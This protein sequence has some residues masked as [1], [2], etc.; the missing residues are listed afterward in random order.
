MVNQAESRFGL[1]S[2]A[3][4]TDR[5]S[6]IRVLDPSHVLRTPHVAITSSRLGHNGRLQ[7]QVALGLVDCALRCRFAEM[8]WLIALDSAIA[9]WALRAAELFQI[10]VTTL[11][12]DRDADITVESLKDGSGAS[13]DA[14]VIG[15]ANQV[16]ALFVRRG[17]RIEAK[18]AERVNEGRGASTFIARVSH[19]RCAANGLIEH[20]ATH[21]RRSDSDNDSGDADV[22]A[23]RVTA[24]AKESW[25]TS[26][27]AWLVHC[28]RG[29]L[30]PWPDETLRQY[31][32]AVLLG[33][34]DVQQRG[35]LET[36]RRIL[37]SGRLLTSATASNQR[38]PV[39]CFSASPLQNLIAMRRFRPHLGR[40][41]YEP[42]G[43]AIR[44][45]TAERIGIRPVIYGDRTERDGLPTEERYRFHPVGRTYDWRCETEWRSPHT[46][47]LRSLDD[48]DVRVFAATTPTSKL[49][50]CRWRITWGV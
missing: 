21:R 41:D 33:N 10:P 42:F 2:C 29:R 39:V 44:T 37:R 20:G 40:W 30:A 6:Q 19:P 47:D 31:Q 8:R 17:G 35:P 24:I 28:T 34:A 38:Y 5:R 46:I 15:L 36:L 27:G 18:L 16:E 9:D 11:S 7:R 49:A 48:C 13:R 45:Q 23:T 43:I 26:S 3:D 50:F 14:A 25:T 1:D 22:E 4:T 12:V 32:D